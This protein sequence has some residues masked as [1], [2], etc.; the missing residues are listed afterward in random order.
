MDRT[1]TSGASV[2]GAPCP[3]HILRALRDLPH[4]DGFRVEFVTLADVADRVV[5]L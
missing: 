1:D 4:D 3:L 5:V 2:S